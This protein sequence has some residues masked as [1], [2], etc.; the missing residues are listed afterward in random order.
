MRDAQGFDDFYQGT[1]ARLV[2]YLFAASGDLA[3]AQDAAQE[4]YTRA[5]Q[6]WPSLAGSPD[7]EA[8]VRTVGWRVLAHRWRSLRSR[9]RAQ[10]QQGAPRSSPAPSEDTVTLVA[11]LRQLPEP[12]RQALVLHHLLDLP[13]V[14]IAAETGV[15]VGTLKARLSRGRTALAAI[16][17]S[18]FEEVD[19]A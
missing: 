4:A 2:A 17:G 5:W 6:R 1:R 3:E 15:P 19:R 7:P 10:Y 14:Q 13:V 12:Q 16:L 18:H 9:R 8:W 11:A